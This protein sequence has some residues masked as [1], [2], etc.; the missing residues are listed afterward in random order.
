[1][2]KCKERE[3]KLAAVAVYSF[4]FSYNDIINRTH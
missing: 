4:L 3:E 1:M 2:L